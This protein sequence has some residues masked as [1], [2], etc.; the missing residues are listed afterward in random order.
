MWLLLVQINKKKSKQ[1]TLKIPVPI[2]LAVKL[3]EIRLILQQNLK[4][5][6]IIQFN[7]YHC[8]N[9]RIKKIKLHLSLCNKK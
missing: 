8:N 9:K 5:P 4:W 7:L 3:A 6:C 2:N 1:L